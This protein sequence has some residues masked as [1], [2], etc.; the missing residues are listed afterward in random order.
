MFEIPHAVLYVELKGILKPENPLAHKRKEQSM[1]AEDKQWTKTRD[2]LREWADQPDL[3]GQEYL[4]RLHYFAA[5]VCQ[6]PKEVAGQL[7]TQ[8][9]P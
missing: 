3:S 2:C 1:G 8:S 7:P 9:A 5:Y 4:L 6:A